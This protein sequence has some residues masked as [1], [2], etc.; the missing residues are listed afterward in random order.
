MSD[1]TIT[2]DEPMSDR[3]EQLRDMAR[4]LS[5]ERVKREL[6]TGA[7][8]RRP[9]DFGARYVDEAML[10]L[11]YADELGMLKEGSDD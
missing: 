4:K 3:L 10:W 6:A 11:V 2:H 9:H 5:A 8:Q 7:R 1:Y